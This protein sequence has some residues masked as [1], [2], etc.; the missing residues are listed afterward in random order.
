MDNQFI[1]VASLNLAAFYFGRYKNCFAF[2]TH[3]IWGSRIGFV[4]HEAGA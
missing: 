2:A 4:W 3:S 1:T